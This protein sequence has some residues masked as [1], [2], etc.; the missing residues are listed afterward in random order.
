MFVPLG[1]S[2]YTFQ[3]MGYLI[4]LYYGK[5]KAERNICKLALFT[6]FFPQLIQGP[7][8]RFGDLSKTLYEEHPLDWSNIRL[9]LER[10]LWGYFKKLVIADRMLI[11]VKALIG[12]TE[13]IP[14]PTPLL[15]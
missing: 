10:I 3:I 1:I 14:E 11:A 13:N 9:G 2:F 5:Y 12:N 7:I 15:L 8:S 6:S 4:D